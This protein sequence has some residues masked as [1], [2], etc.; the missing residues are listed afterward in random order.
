MSAGAGHPAENLVSY[1]IRRLIAAVGLVIVISIIVFAIFYLM[2]RLAGASPETLATRYVGRTAPGQPSNRP[3]RAARVLRPRA[4]AVLELGQGRRRRHRG[5]PRFRRSSSARR[6]VWATPSATRIRCCRDHRAVPGDPVPGRRG[7]R[8][9]GWSSA[10]RIGVL[11]A[12][13]RGSFFDRF[14]MMVALAGVSMP[15]FWT[16]LMA[17]SIFSY[18]LGW[19]PPGASYIAVHRQPGA[20]GA[21]TVAAVDHA[22]AALLR[23]VRPTD[24]RGH[25]GDH[26]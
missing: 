22:R 9:S 8:S 26:G 10:S 19:T 18:K 16:G 3:R 15:I 21:R 24:P 14:A 4:R 20:V 17:L 13:K 11:S 1:I 5:R 23:A 6:R 2:P 12:L 7:R 25:A